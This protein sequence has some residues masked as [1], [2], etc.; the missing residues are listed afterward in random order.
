[1]EL[2]TQPTV[3]A[4]LAS[5]PEAG[6]WMYQS[7]PEQRSHYLIPRTTPDLEELTHIPTDKTQYT[8]KVMTQRHQQNHI[9]SI[10][11]SMNKTLMLPNQTPYCPGLS[12]EILSM[13]TTDRIR[14]QASPGGVQPAPF[15]SM[16]TGEFLENPGTVSV[17]KHWI[18]CNF[19]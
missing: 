8:L 17:F 10:N 14:D 7:W 6:T 2:L 15:G 13:R 9:I 12:L 19:S 18:Q 3:G 4:H 1:M 5:G 11:K 16:R